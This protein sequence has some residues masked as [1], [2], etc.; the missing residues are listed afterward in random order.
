ML[1]EAEQD[2]Q[3]R[4]QYRLGMRVCNQQAQRVLDRHLRYDPAVLR[5]SYR[6]DWR[7]QRGF[8]PA[9]VMQR[10]AM[11]DPLGAV[12]VMAISDDAEARARVTPLCRALLAKFDFERT[13]SVEP[14]VYAEAAYAAAEKKW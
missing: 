2:P 7:T 12:F 13:T 8:P 5:Q 4:H 11:H 3:L 10:Q 1:Y 6:Y 14:F 9:W